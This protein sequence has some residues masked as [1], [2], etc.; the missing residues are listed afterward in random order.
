MGNANASA[1]G[2]GSGSGRS[3]NKA[4]AVDKFAAPL[5]VSIT[6]PDVAPGVEGTR[7]VKVRLGNTSALNIGRI[8][9]TLRAHSHHFVLSMVENPAETEQALFE[10]P[11]FRAPLVG[12]PLT[13]TQK[14]EENIVL[15]DGVGYAI[16]PNQLLHLE[17]HYINP[18]SDTS[19]VTAEAELYPLAGDEPVQQAGFLV[20]GNLNI[21]I[22]PR[23]EHSSGDVFAAQPPGL[24]AAHYYALTGHTHRFGTSVRVGVADTMAAD[25]TW[26]YKPQTFDW[27]A[28][29]VEYLDPP[30]QVPEG[31]GFRLR[32]DWNNPTDQT[33]TYGESA[34][35]E[36]CFF[37]AYYYPRDPMQRVVL[38]G[39]DTSMYAKDGG[40][41]PP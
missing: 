19:D 3:G 31:G 20:V 40:M 1:A 34:L 22:P 27:D 2:S 5:K 9:N 12:A 28:P 29:P 35:T 26:L 6:V 8:H 10:C 13:V 4:G 21:S 15:P 11:P 16:A 7:C 25:T 36:M 14:S 23:S 32:C 37:W 18:D 39:F 17:L 33:I 24:E 41:A 30:V 38:A